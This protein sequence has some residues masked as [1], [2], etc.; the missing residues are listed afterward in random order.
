[1]ESFN[2]S[3]KGVFKQGYK[4]VSREVNGNVSISQNIII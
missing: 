2:G 4:I 3:F 1:M